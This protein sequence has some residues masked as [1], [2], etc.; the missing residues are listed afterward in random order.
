MDV[1]PGRGKWVLSEYALGGCPIYASH[2]TAVFQR[3]DFSRRAIRFANES[4]KV[5]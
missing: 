1:A 2:I 3:F 4:R 5:E